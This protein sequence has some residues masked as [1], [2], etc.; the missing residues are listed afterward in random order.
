MALIEFQ[1]PTNI[2]CGADSL[3]KL[4]EIACPNNEK[5][6]MVCEKK[7]SETGL[8]QKIKRLIEGYAYDIIIYE[9]PSNA[10]TK[11]LFEGVN[12]AKTSRT[13]VVIGVG[14]ENVLSVAKCIAQ[15]STQEVSKG[16]HKGGKWINVKK[17]RYIEV[18]S[19]QVVTWGII[20]ITYVI[21][22][23]DRI[24]KPYSDKTSYAEALIIDPLITEDVPLNDLIYSSLEG[25]SY[26]FDA[27]ISKKSNPISDSMSLKA[28]EYL[29]VNLK[30][31]ALEPANT[32][33][34]GNLSIGTLL[35]SLA[36]YGSSPGLSA[37]CSMGLSS[38]S[39]IAQQ[40][41]SG[42]ILPHVMEFN[43]TAAANKFIQIAMALGEKV[44]DI[45]VIEAAIMAIESIRRLMMDLHIPQRLMEYK[46]EQE[47]I[48]KAAQIGSE[49]EFLSYTPRPAGRSE[50]HEI[51]SAAL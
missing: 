30:R 44:A 17:V 21:D 16:E 37:A 22:E 34:K 13:D 20:P 40:I 38:A 6:I 18:P 14:G 49:Y 23:T 48:N 12:I 41:G 50:I 11:D 36:V 26:S 9:I 51:F 47:I 33:I 31:L 28:I 7:Y 1:I 25:I 46:I 29:S 43:L 27:Y 10:S 19:I 8:T 39:D 5:V 42:V 4:S 35:A 15:F 45:T 32:K 24:R 2:I 3:Q